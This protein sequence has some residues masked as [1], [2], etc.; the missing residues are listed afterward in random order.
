MRR[1]SEILSRDLTDFSSKLSSIHVPRPASA[2]CKQICVAAMP[3]SNDARSIFLTALPI[4][5]INSG[6]S[7]T[8]TMIT[9]ACFTKAPPM[10][11]AASATRFFNSVS[12]ITTN[13]QPCV[14]LD[15]GDKRAASK[16][17][18]IFSRSTG[19]S[20]YERLL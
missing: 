20:S 7:A 13:V 3:I 14:L 1:L 12:F 19:L 17:N 5:V 8:S 11:K 6:F 2:A 16:H 4:R 18:S 9:G 15:D 10:R